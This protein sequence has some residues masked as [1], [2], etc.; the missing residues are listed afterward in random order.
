MYDPIYSDDNPQYPPIVKAAFD[1]SLKEVLNLISQGVDLNEKD[2][3]G[4]T[5]VMRA[6]YRNISVIPS[7]IIQNLHEAGADLNLKNNAGDTALMLAVYFS[8]LET[9]DTLL[10]AG[11]DWTI[12]SD[13]TNAFL[14]SC[15]KGIHM[16]FV[17]YFS[18]ITTI[19]GFRDEFFF[20]RS[21]IIHG[22]ETVNKILLNDIDKYLLNLNLNKNLQNDK[23]SKRI[24][25]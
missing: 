7:K 16:E 1:D 20:Y 6:S 5:A 11:A 3:Q 9:M 23:I 8:N 13:N 12:T 18:D 2:N 19:K 24:K 15:Y 25:L 21:E 10:K 4:H 17:S 14:Y 22:T